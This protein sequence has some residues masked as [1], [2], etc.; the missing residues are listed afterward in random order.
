M[1][2]QW[3]YLIGEPMRNLPDQIVLSLIYTV[4]QSWR[5]IRFAVLWFLFEF[6]YSFLFSIVRADNLVAHPK[7]NQAKFEHEEN[8]ISFE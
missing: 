3:T 8:K 1:S 5:L 6:L 7:H 4:F 2:I